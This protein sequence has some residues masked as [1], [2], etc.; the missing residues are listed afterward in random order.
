M[1]KVRSGCNFSPGGRRAAPVH[2][3]AVRQPSHGDTRIREGKYEEI[4]VSTRRLLGQWVNWAFMSCPA[5][6]LG[7]LLFIYIPVDNRED[8]LGFPTRFN[9]G[10][11]A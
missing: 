5:S 11:K 2:A 9:V 8:A 6:S 7:F 3:T 4:L 1:V 10:L